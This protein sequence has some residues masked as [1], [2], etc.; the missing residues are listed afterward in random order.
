VG[1]GAGGGEDGDDDP[2]PKRAAGVVRDV[3]QAAGDAGV[4]ASDAG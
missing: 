4:P 2:E 1:A 3:D